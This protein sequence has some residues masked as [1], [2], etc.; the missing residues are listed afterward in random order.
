MSFPGLSLAGLW[1][2]ARTQDKIIEFYALCVSESPGE[3]VRK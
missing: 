1:H 3:L 2:S